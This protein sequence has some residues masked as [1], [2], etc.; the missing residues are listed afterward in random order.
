MDQFTAYLQ[1]N[2]VS[3]LS[4]LS[5]QCDARKLLKDSGGPFETVAEATD[6]VKDQ[7]SKVLLQPD[8]FDKVWDAVKSNSVLFERLMIE[9]E[10]VVG[11][12]QLRE[13]IQTSFLDFVKVS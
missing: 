9:P 8:Q 4:K 6:F 11:R 3:E 2:N 1:T 5:Y 10:D 13:L 7:F 12:A